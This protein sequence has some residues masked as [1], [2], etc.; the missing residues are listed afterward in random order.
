MAKN[1]KNMF[2][3]FSKSISRHEN[4]VILWPRYLNWATIIVL[5]I[6]D[7][8]IVNYGRRPFTRRTARK[9]RS[10]FGCSKGHLNNPPDPLTGS[11]SIV[12][13]SKIGT[14]FLL[15]F[16]KSGVPTI[17]YFHFHLN[18]KESFFN[19]YPLSLPLSNTHTSL[20][21]STYT[22][23]NQNAK[24]IC[25]SLFLYPHKIKRCLLSC[26]L[27]KTPIALWSLFILHTLSLTFSFFLSLTPITHLSLLVSFTYLCFFNYIH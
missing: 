12:E 7:Y 10:S 5:V 21:L 16:V 27:T 13:R 18:K 8:W 3:K 6:Y 15:F 9:V 19:V 4:I 22:L 25:F 11:W 17:D 23:H 2:Y 24:F 20:S 26:Y 1:C 14:T